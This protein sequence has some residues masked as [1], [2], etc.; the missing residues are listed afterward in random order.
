MNALKSEGFY[1]TEKDKLFWPR[2]TL[3][4]TKKGIKKTKTDALYPGYLFYISPSVSTEIYKLYRRIPGFVR[5]L[6]DNQHIEPL[7]AEDESIICH[8]RSFGE[9][10]ETSKVYFDEQNKIQILAGPMKGLEGK[11]VKVD[12]RK[13][14]AKVVL[15]LYKESFPIDLGFEILAPLEEDHEADKE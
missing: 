5:F 7:S 14:R 8:F 9:I 2:R 1:E 13:R 3:V 10:A 12:K 4:R 11:I 15:N 6:K